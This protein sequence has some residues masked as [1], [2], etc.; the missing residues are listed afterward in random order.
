VLLLDV[1]IC[2]H[3]VRPDTSTE[4]PRIREWLEGALNGHERVG[5]SDVVLASLI[6]LATNARM[7][8]DPLTALD[9]VVAA[10]ALRAAP[11]S[12]WVTPTARHW[13]IFA[14]LV[15]AHRL[16]VNDIPDAWLAALA[17]DHGATLVTRDRGFARFEGL[18]TLNPV[19]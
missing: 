2:L 9:A 10:E 11:A 7:L 4:G 6:R 17:L 18:R 12:T 15:S 14:N 5:V 13:V 19:A 1:N 3:A 16:R 8:P